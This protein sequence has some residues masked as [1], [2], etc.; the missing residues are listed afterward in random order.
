LKVDGKVL[1]DGDQLGVMDHP[2]VVAMAAKYQERPTLD[3]ER[4]I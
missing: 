4:W 3:A 1:H 2:S